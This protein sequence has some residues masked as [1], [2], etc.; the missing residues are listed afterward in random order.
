MAK[1]KGTYIKLDRGLQNNWLWESKPFS[2]GQAWVDLLLEA[3][4]E[5]H[6]RDWKGSYLMQHRGEVFTSIVSLAA[7]W[8]WSEKKVTRF[9]AA[10]ERDKMVRKGV[11]PK[12][13]LLTIENYEKFQGRVRA[14]DRAD[15]RANAEQTTEH[16]PTTKESKEGKE[17]KEYS[18][19]SC[20]TTTTMQVPTRDEV[21]AYCMQR[22]N[23]VD[24]DRFV[25]YYSSNGW[26]VGKNHMKDWKAAVRVWERKESQQ[27]KKPRNEVLEMMKGGMFNE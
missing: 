2:L 9:I 23:N 26:M 27:K 12:G 25:D 7:R 1:G 17:S 21:H 24:A 11:L 5:D 19:S 16:V 8:G 3:A 22:G 4:Y 13:T 10:L 18:K 6:M 14:D 20:R 15:D